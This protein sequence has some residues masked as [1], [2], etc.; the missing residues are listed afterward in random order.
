MSISIRYGTRFGYSDPVTLS[1]AFGI[2]AFHTQVFTR[3]K[4]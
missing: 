4:D 3:F 1:F 2:C